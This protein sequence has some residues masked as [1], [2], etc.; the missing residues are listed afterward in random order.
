MISLMRG[1]DTPRRIANAD[2]E[3]PSGFRNSC[4][5]ISPGCVGG[6]WVGSRRSTRRACERDPFLMVIRDF[7]LVGITVL[8]GKADPKLNIDTNAVLAL[9]IS[10]ECLEAIAG[11]N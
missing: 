1:N 9:P 11:R 5:N 3:I 4:N 2:C 6:R 8:P 7:D 10:L